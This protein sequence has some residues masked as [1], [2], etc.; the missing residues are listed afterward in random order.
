MSQKPFMWNRNNPYAYSDPTGYE[1]QRGWYDTKTGLP[2]NS[3]ESAHD[4]AVTA[5]VIR[6]ISGF[7]GD[8]LLNM[9][10]IAVPLAK[11]LQ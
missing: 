6:E 10:S 3:H 5:N 2:D 11:V 4:R 9:A 8:L 1:S 7:T